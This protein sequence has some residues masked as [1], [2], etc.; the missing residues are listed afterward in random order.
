MNKIICVFGD[1][2]LWGWGLPF[3][4]GWVN[5]FRNYI[6]DKS[7]FTMNLYDLGIDADTTEDVLR[8][9]D[10][11]ASAR[12]PDMVIFAIGVNDSAY[13]KTKD[14][15]L[16]S[17]DVFLKNIYTLI[18]KARKFT[19]EI[20]FVG[21]CKGS[22]QETM[23]LPASKTG[24]C[25]S[26]KNARVYNE[27]IKK[28]CLN[29]NV[30][31]IDIIDKIK[32]SEFC[33]G[34]HPTKE[35]HEKIFKK[36]KESIKLWKQADLFKIIIVD[37]NDNVVGLKEWENLKNEDIYRVSAL[38]VENS[39]G[40]VLLARRALTKSHS[41]GKWGPAVAGTVEN[42]ETYDS[43]IIKEAEEE[44]GLKNLEFLK[45]PKIKISGKHN[46]FLQWYL[47][48]IDKSLEDFKIQKSEVEEIRWFSK[49]ELRKKISANP[50][51]FIVSTNQ[52]IKLFL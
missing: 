5:L 40:E 21:L 17:A 6:E 34:L 23:P 32:D 44:L 45:G 48:K 16:V 11:E 26:K 35:G 50:D 7:N 22:D 19:K 24:K 14:W 43:N 18:K 33:D 4:I 8:R 39:K 1:S 3:R 27:I 29:E 41:P 52:W 13:R 28:C 37:K 47:L 10:I 51:E 36:V 2:V 42:K 15:P 30:L 46:Y 38:W 31:F 9:F 12:K 25:F 20:V 49:D